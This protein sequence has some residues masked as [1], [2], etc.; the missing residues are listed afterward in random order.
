MIYNPNPI[1]KSPSKSNT[2]PSMKSSNELKKTDKTKPSAKRKNFKICE[3]SYRI[4]K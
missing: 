4:R 2:K 3:K 1:K